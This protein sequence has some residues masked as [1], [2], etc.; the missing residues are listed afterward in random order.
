[1]TETE[2]AEAVALV[3]QFHRTA[4]PKPTY[5]ERLAFQNRLEE[6]GVKLSKPI[7]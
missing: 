5:W 4:E 3:A 7:R 1:M 6:L 2:L